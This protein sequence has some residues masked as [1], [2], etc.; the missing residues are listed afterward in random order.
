MTP[1]R[2]ISFKVIRRN[3]RGA[4]IRSYLCDDGNYYSRK[5]LSDIIGFTPPNFDQRVKK[6]GLYHKDLLK[7]SEV[8]TFGNDEFKSLD[9]NN[10]RE[11]I[12]NI[13]H[14]GSWESKNL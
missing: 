3:K 5:Q 11:K 10:R 14:K 13:K 12:K 7:P 6:L 2:V 4:E 9:K 8:S 1:T